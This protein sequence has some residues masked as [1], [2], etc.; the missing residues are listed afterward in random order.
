MN[1]WNA[2]WLSWDVTPDTVEG[3]LFFLAMVALYLFFLSV[4]TLLLEISPE[5]YRT[6]LSGSIAGLRDRI[7]EAS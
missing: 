4:Q 2:S 5:K 3:L 6:R 7:P 1:I